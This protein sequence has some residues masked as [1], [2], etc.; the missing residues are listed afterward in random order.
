MIEN[1]STTFLGWL[2]GIPLGLWFLDQYVRT[3]STIRLEY[4][5]YV[6]IQTLGLATVFVWVFSMTTT[7]FIS[8]RI[9]K[10]DMVEALKGVE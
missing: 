6:N 8:R 7:F 3:F 1:I 9:R 5:A 4:T 2:L 10:L